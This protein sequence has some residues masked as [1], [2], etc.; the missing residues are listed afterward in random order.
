MI[1]TL[2]SNS[3]S[4]LFDKTGDQLQISNTRDEDVFA[5]QPI[6]E[7]KKCKVY[8]GATLGNRL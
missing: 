4:L 7:E 1:H 3:G 2:W 6:E 8:P 5:T